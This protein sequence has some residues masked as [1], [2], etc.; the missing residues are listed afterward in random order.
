[1]EFGDTVEVKAVGLG[2]GRPSESS[3]MGIL[4]GVSLISS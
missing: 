4:V 3:M 2:V 1:V